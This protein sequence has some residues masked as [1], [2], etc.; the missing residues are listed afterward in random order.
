MVKARDP[1]TPLGSPGNAG[2]SRRLQDQFGLLKRILLTEVS[3]ELEE[4]HIP[5]QVGLADTTEHPQ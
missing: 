5:R 2:F 1:F 3:Q 4:A